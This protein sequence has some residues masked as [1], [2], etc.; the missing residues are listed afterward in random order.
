MK[1]EGS[2]APVVVLHKVKIKEESTN[3]SICN[4]QHQQKQEISTTHDGDNSPTYAIEST[5]VHNNKNINNNNSKDDNDNNINITTSTATTSIITS[6]NNSSIMSS[7]EVGAIDFQ[8]SSNELNIQEPASAEHESKGESVRKNTDPKDKSSYTENTKDS[9]EKE[10]KLSPAY[11]AESKSS[12]SNERLSDSSENRKL[13]PVKSIKPENDQ[14]SG[15]AQKPQESTFNSE[16]NAQ[17]KITNVGLKTISSIFTG[18]TKLK[19]LLGTLVQFANNISTETGETVRNL[20]FGLLSS[21]LS[22]EEFHSALQEATNFPLRDFVLP[23]LKHTLPSL[24]RNI[25]AAAQANNQTCVQYLQSNESAV[26]ETV[27]HIASAEL[28]VQLFNDHKNS[29]NY[30]T[31]SSNMIDPNSIVQ[32]SNPYSSSSHHH[33][34]GGIKR[35]ASDALYYENNSNTEETSMYAK[36]PNN[37]WNQQT[38]HQLQQQQSDSYWWHPIHSST[39]SGQTHSQS[40]NHGS[41]NLLLPNLV[42]INHSSSFGPHHISHPQLNYGSSNIQNNVSLD[43]EWKNIHVMLNCILGMIEKTKRALLI[44]QKRGCSS[45]V[46]SSSLASGLNSC[47]QNGNNIGNNNNINNICTNNSQVESSSSVTDRDSNL[48]RL[49]GEIVAQTIRATE[50]RVAAEVKKRAEEAMQEVK[51]A[52]MVEVQRAVAVAVAESR[53]NERLRSHQLLDV[54]LS[55]KDHVNPGSFLRLNNHA[56]DLSS[57]IITKGNV[58][59][60]GINNLSG[61]DEKDGIS[62]SNIPGS[63]SFRNLRRMWYCKIL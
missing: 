3:E 40:S 44:L 63:V 36:R 61:E 24:R 38:S 55:Q 34:T 57:R 9:H 18:H 17:A 1:V 32:Q 62:L 10:R 13:Y 12:T 39:N 29:P 37:L 26:L 4:L 33:Y 43:D 20:I 56:R 54:R 49:S 59:T 7:M 58:G 45:P 35:R 52:A 21:G 51:R 28:T 27:S 15:A 53:A 2:T 25:N 48:K 46:T 6:I 14:H 30:A 16:P 41:S 23:Y 5:V 42:Q 19:R 8:C 50:D 60:V 22:A 11:S 31:H 47:T